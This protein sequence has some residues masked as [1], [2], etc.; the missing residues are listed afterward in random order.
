M[1]LFDKFKAALTKTH[2]KLT[3]EIK[4]IV[5]RS[6]KLDSAT[7]EEIE[8]ALIGADL[9]LEMTT[10]IVSAVKKAYESQGSAG[11]DV[12]EEEAGVFFHD[13]SG[14]ILTDDVLARL[15]TFNNV[16]VTS[17]QAF[18]TREALANIADTTFANIAEFVEGKR[19]VE[20]TNAVKG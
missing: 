19:G 12:Y 2:D 3:H 16:V 13:I 11:L 8:V 17:H 4:R 10:Q 5:T 7:L 18:L 20:L 9:G 6:P 14:K 15:M 1:G